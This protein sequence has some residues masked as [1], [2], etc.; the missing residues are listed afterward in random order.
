MSAARILSQTRCR[1]AQ[2]DSVAIVGDRRADEVLG[3]VERHWR[4][5]GTYRQGLMCQAV[6]LGIIPVKGEDGSPGPAHVM[7]ALK[8]LGGSQVRAHHQ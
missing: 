7:H 4:G 6:E 1:A 5:A 8:Q 2:A 3:R